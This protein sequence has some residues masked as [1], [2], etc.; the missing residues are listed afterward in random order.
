MLIQ[1]EGSLFD[2]EH[3]AY[4]HGVSTRGIMNAGIAVDFKSRYPEMFEIYRSRCQKHELNPGDCF[5][6]ESPNN[7]PSVFNLITQDNL[8]RASGIYL[9]TSFAKMHTIAK[10]KDISDIAMPEIGCGLGGLTIDILIA[11]L[12]PFISDP[13][14]HVTIYSFNYDH[15][16]S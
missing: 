4:A 2:Y 9:K 16:F 8:L 12:H 15:P 1:S 10:V 11:S 13:S 5:Y 14:H 6:Y 3:E 7:S